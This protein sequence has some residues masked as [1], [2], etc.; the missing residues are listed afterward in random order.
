MKR[1][2]LLPFAVVLALAACAPDGSGTLGPGPTG[3]PRATGDTA[4]SGSPVPGSSSTPA[5]TLT[6][7]VWFVREGRLFPTKRTA[8]FT[9]ETSRLALT[10]LMIGPSA[11]EAAAGVANAIPIGMDFD[12]RGI[13]NGVAT[14]GFPDRFHTDGAALARLRQAQVVYTLTQYPSVSRVDFRTGTPPVGRAD[15]TDLLPRVVVL[16][17]VVGQRVSSPVT[18]TGTAD[19]R[20]ATVNVRLLDAAG[21]EIATT[22]TTATCGNGCRGAYSVALPYQGCAEQAGT[23][24]VYQISGEDGSRR[25]VVAIPIVLSAC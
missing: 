5:R 2:M 16:G 14:V 18:V 22:F 24:E 9:V 4:A 12:L 7:Q 19:T 23:L 15:F 17:P 10:E 25:D 3:A 11:V 21:H 20:E 13:A 1:L 8:P 6:I